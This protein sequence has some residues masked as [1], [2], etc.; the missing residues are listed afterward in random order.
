M[1]AETSIHTFVLQEL[2]LRDTADANEA[3]GIV[4]AASTG[5][6]PAVPLLTSIDDERDVAIVR[7]LPAGETPATDAEQRESLAGLV[8]TWQPQQRYIPRITERSRSVPSHYRL[9][10]TGSGI[11]NRDADPIAARDVSEHHAERVPLDLLW[12]GV[13]LGTYAGLLVLLGGDEE[14]GAARSD[15]REWPLPF[16]RYLGV[17]IYDSRR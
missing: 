3:A 13:P 15:P 16:S 4:A 9:A 7:A 11:N 17:R 6:G 14:S 1:P 10:V 8:A 12:V 2:R 5:T